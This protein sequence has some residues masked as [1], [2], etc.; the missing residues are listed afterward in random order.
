AGVPAG[1][2]N[3]TV[4][5]GKTF[6]KVIKHKDIQAVS[7]TG[8]NAVGKHIYKQANDHRKRVLLEMGGQNPLIVLD[9]ADI[10]NAAELAV[11]GSFSNTGQSCTGTGRIIV[12]NNI[13]D[14]FIK[15]LVEKTEEIRV[16]SP[17]KE[18][19][20]MGPQISSHEL[21]SSIKYIESARKEG[22]KILHGG[23]VIDSPGC[24]KGYFMQPTIMS[25]VTPSMQIAKEEVFGPV[26]S[27]MGVE[28]IKQ[29]VEIANNVEYG[30]S[31]AVCT[32]SIER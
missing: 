31:A 27:I 25:E 3:F 15:K 9:D 21:N 14:E 26:V 29:A 4:A 16:D 8:S 7:F 13:M 22:A 30:L 24:E 10:D 19:T 17:L 2:V 1:V 5:S 12:Q 11:K 20:E 6:E 28:D 32:K 23:N 18:G